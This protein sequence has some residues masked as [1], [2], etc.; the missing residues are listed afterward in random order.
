MGSEM[1]IRDRYSIQG[2]IYY[3]MYLALYSIQGIIYYSVYLALYS[4][5][6]IIYSETEKGW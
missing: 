6:G 3:S 4:I 1:C 2:N 5:Q